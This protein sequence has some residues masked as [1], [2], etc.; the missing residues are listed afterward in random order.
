MT[1]QQATDLGT[2]VGIFMVS[3]GMA[4]LIFP[5]FKLLAY[6]ATFINGGM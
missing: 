3:L 1:R 2:N 4:L 5:S 6:V